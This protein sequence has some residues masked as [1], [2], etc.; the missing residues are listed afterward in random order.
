MQTQT[1]TDSGK[2]LEPVLSD[3]QVSLIEGRLR[4]RWFG[5]VPDDTD[6]VTFYQEPKEFTQGDKTV[7]LPRQAVFAVLGNHPTK[8]KAPRI[9]T[10]GTVAASDF[11]DSQAER[12]H[13]TGKSDPAVVIFSAVLKQHMTTIGNLRDLIN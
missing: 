12:K 13:F 7:M 1:P 8:K 6:F 10:H 4:E 5:A 3:Y 2:D 11:E 9:M